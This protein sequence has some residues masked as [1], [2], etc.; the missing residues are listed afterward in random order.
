M[1]DEQWH[2]FSSYKVDDAL[3]LYYS[4]LWG[5]CDL[6]DHLVGKHPELINARGGQMVTLLVAA[7]RGEYLRVAELLHRDGADFDVRGISG[8]TLLHKAC[9][10]GRL[11]LVDW[12]LNRG[13]GCECPE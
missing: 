7:L 1:V 4:P 5:F 8:N 11:F 10:D 3:P 6:V 13:G 2:G 12:L 9:M